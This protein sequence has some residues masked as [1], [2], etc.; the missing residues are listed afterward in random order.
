MTM[1]ES[2]LEA[3]SVV[4]H[5]PRCFGCGAANEMTMGIRGTREGEVMTAQWLPP[6]YAEGG[7][8]IVHGG[9]LSAAVDEIQALLAAAVA[10]V[11][12]MTAKMD[13]RY[14]SPVLVG[15]PL[16]LRAEVTARTGRKMTL[17][18]TAT[19]AESGTVCF[20]GSGLYIAVA[21]ELWLE[22]LARHGKNFNQLDL[23]GG[24]VTSLFGWHVR[25]LREN[26]RP[27]PITTP[28][29]IL[30]EFDGI[31]PSRWKFHIDEDGLRIGPAD[32]SATAD[33]TLG[34]IPFGVWQQMLE[35][36]SGLEGLLVA[37][38]HPVAGTAHA[39]DELFR[40][41]PGGHKENEQ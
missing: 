29:A 5:Y 18:M 31:T 15:R 9:Y 23:S 36:R 24:D 34:P 3:G 19:D 2:V 8:G 7:P 41:L 14:R 39:V 28:V 11:P 4:D 33:A 22:H 32:D 20:E 12:A 1:E 26:Y 21:Q 38:G 30:V 37:G 35:K 25:W 10:G 6:A 27:A 16:D 17:S 40:Q 13:I